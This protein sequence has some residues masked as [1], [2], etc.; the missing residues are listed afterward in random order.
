LDNAEMAK[1]DAM[2]YS[3]KITAATAGGD[4]VKAMANAQ[5]VL[6]SKGK[7][8]KY[9][10]NAKNAKADLV[11]AKEDA[12]KVAVA[13]L[14]TAIEEIDGYIAKIQAI[15][16][17]EGG[18]S[19]DASITSVTTEAKKP[20]TAAM[21][22]QE[23]AEKIFD[24]L[25]PAAADPTTEV[26]VSA[27]VGT[28][29]VRESNHL[30]KTWEEIVGS[31][32]VITKRI[33]NDNVTEAK[34]ATS[35]DSVSVDSDT[36]APLACAAN[37]G[38][39]ADGMQHDVN[40]KGIEGKIFCQ[41][42]DCKITV[43]ETARTLTGSWY[44]TPDEEKAYFLR[45][46]DDRD[47]YVSEFY[48]EYGYW[49]SDTGK[50]LNTFSHVVSDSVT[51]ENPTEGNW[52]VNAA[53]ASDTDATYSG[54]AIGLYSK[55]SGSGE[56]TTYQSGHFSADA[57]LNAE[58]GS[59]AAAKVSGII[60]NFRN[61]DNNIIDSAW[62]VGLNAISSV[63]GTGSTPGETGIKNDG[64]WTAFSIADDADSRPHTIHGT[65]NAHFSNGDVAGAYATRKD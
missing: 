6:D 47:N 53:D 5:K 16:D 9:L 64:A 48:A 56:N 20:K 24:V 32:N 59:G 43:V 40:W 7:V 46:E 12:D 14:E 38:Q 61:A 1:K 39:C 37:T 30:G 3:G 55:S 50:V 52:G 60:N 27:E 28:N 45:N 19:L 10:M 2:K 63:D 54:N 29:A 17:E 49:L 33:A 41:G 23:V 22:G 65:F 26:T 58:F 36:A 44:F 4:S 8:E 21:I 42:K 25:K 15:L 11:A 35:V 62:S 18:D 34:K 51:V 13:S 31:G 57:E